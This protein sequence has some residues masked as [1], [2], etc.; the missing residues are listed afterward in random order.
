MEVTK[1]KVGAEVRGVQLADIGSISK[2]LKE[3]I[4]QLVHK[5]RLLIFKNQGKVSGDKQ[6]E[7][8]SWFGPLDGTVFDGDPLFAHPKCPHPSVHRISNDPEEGCTNAGRSGWH[9]DG[10]FVE[11]PFLYAFLHMLE[12]PKT[13][14]TGTNI[15]L[16]HL[17]IYFSFIFMYLFTKDFICFIL[18]LFYLCI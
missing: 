7:I 16:F 11:E 2:P 4:K 13:G 14:A 6:V 12:V 17:F 10:S 15:Y 8:S 1:V 5:H 18:F 9:I 3:E